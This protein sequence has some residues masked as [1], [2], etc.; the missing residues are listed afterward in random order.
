MY[1]HATRYVPSKPMFEYYPL[2]GVVPDREHEQDRTG[3][4]V[5]D[6][7][8]CAGRLAGTKMRARKWARGGSGGMITGG[9]DQDRSPRDLRIER[10]R[11]CLRH[12]GGADARDGVTF[13]VRAR[14]N[15]TQR[16]AFSVDVALR[17]QRPRTHH[18]PFILSIITAEASAHSRVW[19]SSSRRPAWVRRLV[20]S[21]RESAERVGVDAG[22]ALVW[23]SAVCERLDTASCDHH[24]ES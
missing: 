7:T 10:L 14:A 2:A 12:I 9:W 17:P 20:R 8:M 21:I 13:W 22:P 3:Q 11:Q 4:D 18:R 1:G 24:G 5:A 16:H 19:T 15:F 6:D 23:V